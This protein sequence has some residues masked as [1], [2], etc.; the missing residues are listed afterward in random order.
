MPIFQKRLYSGSGPGQ[1]TV[2]CDIMPAGKEQGKA[3][4]GSA[5][6]EESFGVLPP[7]M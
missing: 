2:L 1:C 7:C 3:A 5:E 6:A 4:D